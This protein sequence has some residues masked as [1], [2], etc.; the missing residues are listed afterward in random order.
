M[1][2]KEVQALF[3]QLC[4]EQNIPQ[5]VFDS[6]ESATLPVGDEGLVLHIQYRSDVE[7]VVFLSPLGEIPDDSAPYVLEALLAA[8]L[9]WQE[10]FGATLAWNPEL[11]QPVLQ[12]SVPPANMSAGQLAT[13]LDDYL[14]A[15]NAWREKIAA[16]AGG[17]ALEPEPDDS[18]DEEVDEPPRFGSDFVT[19]V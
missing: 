11:N 19:L 6:S 15:A 18:E 1:S 12:Y 14:A 5:I 2:F 3:E 10:T 4:N 13:A 16:L 9:Y 8:N 7:D 17:G